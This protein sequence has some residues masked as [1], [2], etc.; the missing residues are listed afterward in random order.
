[1]NIGGTVIGDQ[2]Y[3]DT[4]ST[5]EVTTEANRVNLLL[6]R[7][8]VDSGEGS[9]DGGAWD[10]VVSGTVLDENGRPHASAKVEVYLPNEAYS[11]GMVETKNDGTFE[12]GSLPTGEN[13]I[14]RIVPWWTELA[15]A[16]INFFID[17]SSELIGDINLSLGTSISGQVSNIPQGVEVR[18]IFAELVDAAICHRTGSRRQ[19]QA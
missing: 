8:A 14:L 13:L 6:Y 12:F 16:F 5:V 7:V 17:D 3:W 1:L 15:M 4:W 2:E 18:T 19:L 10:G 11:L 9:E